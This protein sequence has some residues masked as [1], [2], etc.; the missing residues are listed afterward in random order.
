MVKQIITT[1]IGIGVGFTALWTIVL[2]LNHGNM[3]LPYSQEYYGIVSILLWL[4]VMQ[5]ER[6]LNDGK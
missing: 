5:L 1:I 4:W 6:S 2:F 3:D